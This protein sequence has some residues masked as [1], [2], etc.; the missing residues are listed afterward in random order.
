MPKAFDN[1]TNHACF[2][3]VG[4]SYKMSRVQIRQLKMRLRLALYKIQ[5]NQTSRSVTSLTSPVSANFQSSY[6]E[7]PPITNDQ[8]CKFSFAQRISQLLKCDDSIS[9]SSSSSFSSSL[10]SSSSNSSDQSQYSTPFK[11]GYFLLEC[12]KQRLKQQKLRNSRSNAIAELR[13]IQRYKCLA[14]ARKTCSKRRNLEPLAASS[15][16][17]LS[18][19]SSASQT[20]SNSSFN[21]SVNDFSS[22]E[23]QFSNRSRQSHPINPFLPSKYTLYKY[24]QNKPHKHSSILNRHKHKQ[25]NTNLT[26]SSDKSI[27]SN[28]QFTHITPQ[29]NLC[30]FPT[31][32]SDES[33][34]GEFS[35]I[36]PPTLLSLSS[37]PNDNPKKD[38]SDQSE[39]S[40]ISVTGEL[41]RSTPIPQP[42]SSLGLNMGSG[43][44]S[45]VELSS[46]SPFFLDKPL[47]LMTE[48]GL[49]PFSELSSNECLS[50]FSINDTR[51]THHNHNSTNP[52]IKINT[53][54]D[55]NQNL[56]KT[57][58]KSASFTDLAPTP[59]YLVPQLNSSQWQLDD[60]N[61]NIPHAFRNRESPAPSQLQL[62]VERSE[63]KTTITP[64]KT[65]LKSVSPFN[66]EFGFHT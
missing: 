15:L 64:S 11:H 43:A 9:S 5:T 44:S 13:R 24:K 22:S 26:Q 35:T 51:Q 57:H 37:E 4:S 18:I 10:D 28:H 47:P 6:K 40:L 63:T 8:F 29:T 56:N 48:T 59:G 62:A 2:L 3:S 41:S 16:T 61:H 17:S 27:S 55:N 7:I 49:L 50:M 36:L 30:T 58:D 45:P 34:S 66:A 21:S 42:H 23:D 12:E 52:H 1:H 33:Q 32:Q 38:G 53:V 39:T 20:P 46:S 14:C 19:V 54:F 31:L 65:I 60:D 25:I